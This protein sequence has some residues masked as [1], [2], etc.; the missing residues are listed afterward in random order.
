MP[1][2][3]TTHKDRAGENCVLTRAGRVA[4]VAHNRLHIRRRADLRDNHAVR[5]GVERRLDPGAPGL[6]DAAVGRAVAGVGALRPHQNRLTQRH[7]AVRMSAKGDPEGKR[8]GGSGVGLERQQ[9]RL[10]VVS[11]ER[12]SGAVCVVAGAGAPAR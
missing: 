11:A 6:G 1:K 9:E 5:A 4:A 8:V 2:S 10:R 12:R 7:T 3:P